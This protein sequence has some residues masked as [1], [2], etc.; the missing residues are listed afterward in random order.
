M[1]KS[2]LKD[3]L[4][5]MKKETKEFKRLALKAKRTLI[6]EILKDLEDSREEVSLI[7]R[8]CI[9][10]L[11]EGNTKPAAQPRKAKQRNP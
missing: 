7:G 5:D 3:L 11:K 2:K 9:E 10:L 8:Q 1:A 4:K 6:P